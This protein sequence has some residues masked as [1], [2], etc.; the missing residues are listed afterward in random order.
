MLFLKKFHAQGFKSYADNISFTFDEHVTG[1]VGPNGSGKS[2]VV[3]ALKWVLGERSMKNLR[4][5][6]SDDVIFFGSQEK[7]ASKFAEVSLT[8]DNSQGYLHDKRKEITVTRRV[9]RGSGVSEYLINNEPSSLK[10]INDI[11]LDSGLTKGSLCIISQNTVSSFIEAKPEDRRQIFEDAAGIGRYAKKKQDAIRQIARTNDNLKE[12]TTIVNELNRDLKKLN[13]QAEKAILYAETKEKL[14][15]LEITLSVNEYLISQKEIEAL[16]EQIAEIDER[17][18][19]ND[20]QLQINQE[21]LEAFKK[22]YNSADQNVQKI[23]DELQK[24]YDEIVLLEK[25]NVFNDLQLKSDLDSNDKNKK[26]NALEQLLKS[27]EEQLK[28]YFELIST[29]EEELKEKDVDKTDLANELENL[30]K[31]LATFQVK[32]Y[33]ANLQVQ[34]YQNQKINQFAQDAGVRTVLN[35]KDA[36]GGVHGIVQDF[37]K[38]E[39][40]YELAISTALNKAAKNIIVDSNQDAINAVNFLKANKAGRATF[41]PLANLKDRDVKPEHLEVLEQVEGYLGIAANLVNYHDQY[42]P[43][44]RALLGQIIIASDLE[45]ATK[46]SKFTYQLYR[47]ISLGGDI[48]NAGGAITGGAESKQT[49]SLFN[50]DEKIDTLK[51]ELLVAEKNI[52]ELNKKLEFLTADYTKKDK[53]FNEQK[54]A[55]QRYQDLIVIEQKKLDDYKI[56]YEQLTDKTFD[57]K[58]VKWD[59]KKIKDKLFSLETKKATLVQ[60]LKINQEAKDMYQKQVNQLEKDVTLFYKEIDEDKNDKLKRREQLTKHENTIYLAKSKINESYNMAIEFAIENYNKPLPISLSQARS[61]VVKLQSTLNNLGAINMEAIQELDIKKERYEKLYSQQQELINARERINQ[62]IIRLDEKA[63][64]EFDQLINN[65]NKELPKTF[66]Y[67]FGGGNCEIRYSNPEEKL[68]SGIEVFASPPGKNIGNLNLLSGGEKAL[69]ALSVL[70]SILKVSSFPLVVLDEAESALDLANVE[71]FA[72][73]IKNSSDQTQFLIIT[74]RE[75]TMV[76]CDKLI[77]ATMQT[78]GVTKMLS[79]SLHQ[80][81]DMAEEIESQ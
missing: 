16:S 60:D 80:A 50:L 78:K 65:L 32:R 44:I 81:K 36:I 38:V 54:I 66:Y 9:Y 41:L 6:T 26:I 8:F 74:H 5:K 4:G 25:R 10:E 35:N 22:R 52:N 71:R 15:D 72:N 3:D 70:F 29:W 69:V 48:V 40:E 23:Q 57:G 53:E 63:I 14:K 19:K 37:I 51:N 28:K 11:F 30:K 21:K 76:K 56:Q 12:I 68:T 77:G 45:A 24:I 47:V 18:L 79:V 73:I 62:A 39:P 61:E 13:Q 64:F 17:L 20:P 34:F 75:G 33:E 49:H 58:D 55:I 67:L 7:P 27:S 59:D 2:N 43:A 46:I 42:D 1:I 31:S